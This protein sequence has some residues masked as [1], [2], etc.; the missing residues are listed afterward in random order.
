MCYCSGRQVITK[1]QCSNLKVQRK[2]SDAFCLVGY[3]YAHKNERTA[4][5]G[6]DCHRLI[7]EY[8][9]GNDCRYG[10]EIDVVGGFHGSDFADNPAPKCKAD[11]R[12]HKP[13]EKQIEPDGG[14]K[15]IVKRE[16][17]W[18]YGKHGK[19]C[20]ESIEENFPRDEYRT[21]A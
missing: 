19:Y 17:P 8:C 3:I 2:T 4:H 16:C 7:E 20:Y 13:Q 12:C 21:I 14:L 10:V 9:A 6:H 11:E 18:L 1:L 5:V 15:E